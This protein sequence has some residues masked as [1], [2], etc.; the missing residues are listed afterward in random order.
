MIKFLKQKRCLVWLTALSTF[1]CTVSLAN[2]AFPADQLKIYKNRTLEA[3]TLNEIGI[4]GKEVST[5]LSP[6]EVDATWDGGSINTPGIFLEQV[7]GSTTIRRRDVLLW[8]Y[9]FKKNSGNDDDNENDDDLT[10]I[11]GQSFHVNYRVISRSGVENALSHKKDPSSLILAYIT[12]RPVECVDRGKNKTRCLGRID[13]DFDISRAK[14]SG[15]YL[16]SIEVTIT[17]L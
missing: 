17:T 12:K 4:S 9:Q 2:K 7:Y 15:K 10:Y 11:N 6:V 1:L 13:F 3:V 5:A 8:Y 14:K 16:G